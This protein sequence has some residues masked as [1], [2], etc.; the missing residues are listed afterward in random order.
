M[1]FSA[2][3][4]GNLLLVALLT[5]CRPNVQ[6][7]VQQP[8]VGDVYVV[9]FQP[10]GRPEPRFF[11]YQVKNVRPDAVDLVAARQES[12]EAEVDTSQPGF[13]SDKVLTYTRAEALELLQE[14][15][16]DSQH[17]KLVEVKRQ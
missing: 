14:Q 2:R 16:N 1:P 4:L 7:L 9:Q 10:A 6:E 8:Q 5:A 12:A 3:L 11:L 17:T 15:P 13:F